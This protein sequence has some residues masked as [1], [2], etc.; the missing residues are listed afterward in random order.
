MATGPVF[1]NNTSDL[2]PND[3]G[4]YNSVVLGNNLI[5]LYI[6]G[7][8]KLIAT[9]LVDESIVANVGNVG[10]NNAVI[11]GFPLSASYCQDP[12][13]DPSGGDNVGAFYALDVII[14][15][16]IE[17]SPSDDPSTIGNTVE[18]KS[19]V[20][21]TPVNVSKIDNH[22]YLKTY[23]LTSTAVPTGTVNFAGLTMAHGASN[24]LI[25]RDS[26]YSVGD[27]DKFEEFSFFGVPIRV[28]LINAENKYYLIMNTNLLSYIVA[29]YKMNDTDGTTIVNSIGLPDA[30]YVGG[31]TI[32]GDNLSVPGVTGKALYFNGTV[33]HYADSGQTLNEF[34]NDSFSVN[35]WIRPDALGGDLFGWSKHWVQIDSDSFDVYYNSALTTITHGIPAG[36]QTEFYMVTLVFINNNNGTTSVCGHINGSPCIAVPSS[37]S[38][39]MTAQT[40]STNFAFG[41]SGGGYPF[42]S[43][44]YDNVCFFSKALSAD[45]IAF[46]YNGGAGTESLNS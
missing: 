30:T 33:G 42:I 16:E 39:D 1:Y 38:V 45:E 18:V 32:D 23:Q 6:E 36:V 13:T 44:D 21:G 22:Y 8:D 17:D 9:S 20:N 5:K 14:S 3:R 10:R 15:S 37:I 40:V 19:V 12:V 34:Q 43:G 46:L 27:I 24:E 26:G 28:G 35:L 2:G 41:G 4:V 31:L 7:E 25:V 29:Q 11:N